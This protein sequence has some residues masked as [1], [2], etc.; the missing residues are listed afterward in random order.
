MGA[1]L[2]QPGPS[3]FGG[4]AADMGKVPGHLPGTSDPSPSRRIARLP[5]GA[6]RRENIGRHLF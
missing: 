6:G 4:L 5:G 3:L 1:Q 2:V